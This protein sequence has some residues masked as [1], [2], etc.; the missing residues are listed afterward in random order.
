M[1]ADG[2]RDLFGVRE[3]ISNWVVVVIAQLCRFSE[4]SLNYTLGSE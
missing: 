3:M 1:T 2:H 4:V